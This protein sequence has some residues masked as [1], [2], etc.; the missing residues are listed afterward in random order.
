MTD[1]AFTTP[2]PPPSHTLPPPPPPGYAAAPPPPTG[3]ATPPP[4]PGAYGAQPA[5]YA[6]APPAYG[7]ASNPAAAKNWMNTTALI[8]SLASLITGVTAIAGIV[9]GHLGL[10]AAKRGEAT[11]RGV[12]LA[13]LI[14]GYVL[15]GLG[16]LAIVG[17]IVFF[18][19]IGTECGGD[20]PASWCESEYESTY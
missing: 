3:Y 15:V 12:G 9:F 4:A 19:W 20:N 13:G 6:A 18:G 7:A 5:G 16:I 17:F 2:P 8:L 1:D 14:I 11:N 10:A